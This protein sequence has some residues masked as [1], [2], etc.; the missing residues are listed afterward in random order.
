MIRDFSDNITLEM[1]HLKKKEDK[2]HIKHMIDELEQ[3]LQ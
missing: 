1:M 2:L 3:G